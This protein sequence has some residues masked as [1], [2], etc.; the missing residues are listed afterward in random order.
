M[1]KLIAVLLLALNFYSVFAQDLSF[2]STLCGS[3]AG[4]SNVHVDFFASKVYFYNNCPSTSGVNFPLNLLCGETYWFAYNGNNYIITWD[5]GASLYSLGTLY[6][7]VDF[8][9]WRKISGSSYQW[10]NWPFCNKNE[11]MTYTTTTNTPY[12][13]GSSF[14]SYSLSEICDGRTSLLDPYNGVYFSTSA[15]QIS[16]PIFLYYYYSGTVQKFNFVTGS[17][18]WQGFC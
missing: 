5:D 14:V 2:Y 1:L 17:C 16:P 13:A 10:V 6:S 9:H 11:L 15:G 7:A 4:Y 18:G 8:I 12:A 3:F